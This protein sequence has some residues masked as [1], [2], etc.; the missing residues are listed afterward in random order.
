LFHEGW[1]RKI[2]K[3]RIKKESERV[4]KNSHCVWE[5]MEELSAFFFKAEEEET[6]E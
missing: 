6:H 2:K 4:K 1:A 3:K 5:K